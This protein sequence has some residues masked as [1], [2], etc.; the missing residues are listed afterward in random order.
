MVYYI[1]ISALAH[2]TICILYFM[3]G[4]T[5]HTPNPWPVTYHWL[6]LLNWFCGYYVAMYDVNFMFDITFTL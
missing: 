5:Y 3:V 1:V 4:S 2:K 6:I